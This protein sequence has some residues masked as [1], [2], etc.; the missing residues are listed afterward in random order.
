MGVLGLGRMAWRNLWRQVRRTLI[1]VLSVAFG[2]F[3]AVLMTGLQDRNWEDVINTAARLG[4]GHVT[5]EH[6][7]FRDKPSLSRTVHAPPALLAE[8]AQ[9]EHVVRV[10]QRIS[11]QVMLSTTADSFGAGFIAYDPAREDESTLS[12]LEAVKQGA[13]FATS[14]DGGM[15]LGERLAR[16]LGAELG[17]KVVYTVTDERGEIV[18]GLARVSGIM[19]T[20]APSVDLGMCLLP[21]DA[22]RRV[23]GYAPDESTQ[24]AVFLDTQRRAE[25]VVQALAGLAGRDVA[26]RTWR[27]TQPDL[28]SIIKVKRAG[29]LFF[30]FLILVLC[31]AG[32]FNTLFVSVMERLREFGILTA[33]GFGPVRLFGMVMLESLWVGLL[34]LVAALGITAW[35]YHY[36]ATTGW[37]LS[38]V[39]GTQNAD[40]AGVG[41][42]MVMHVGIYPDHAAVIAV[43]AVVATLLAGLYPAWRAGR[44]EPVEAIKLV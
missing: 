38:A 23:L 36:L 1:T 18:S 2:V 42:S 27:E 20:G 4:G 19:R 6:P 10:V 30:E 7:D 26:V 24:V 34:G 37:D 14:A 35:P 5:L 40:I 3:L 44:V 29:M 16:N 33:I 31:A 43:S 8:L 12:L 13:R 21:L 17:S 32:I 39:Y 28:V 15:V 22:V 9:Q 41:M 11:G 25:D